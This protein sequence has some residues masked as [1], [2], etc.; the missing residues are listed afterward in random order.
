MSSV[1][2]SYVGVQQYLVHML[3]QPAA[4][5]LAWEISVTFAYFLMQWRPDDAI[6]DWRT[7][8]AESSRR[9]GIQDKL[10]PANR[11]VVNGECHQ[12]SHHVT[13]FPLLE[14]GSSVIDR[15]RHC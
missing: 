15:A 6:L 2:V 1:S 11:Q 8:I 3:L 12:N 10:K 9:R 13:I 14:R 7:L 4:A 5:V